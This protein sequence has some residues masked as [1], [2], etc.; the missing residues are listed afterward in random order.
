MVDEFQDVSLDQFNMIYSLS[1]QHRNLVCVGDCD[2][3]IYSFR[4]G[5]NRFALEFKEY[6]PD[7]QIVYMVDNFR[8]TKPIV[9]AANTLIKNNVERFDKT[10][11]SHKD[12]VPVLLY[13]DCIDSENSIYSSLISEGYAPGDIAVIAT[14]NKSLTYFGEKIAPDGS[15]RP[16]DYVVK[17]SVFLALLDILDL[18]ENGFE[19]DRTLYRVLNLAGATRSDFLNIKRE[20]Q[21]TFM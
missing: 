19:N 10:I 14:T 1:E 11:I 8:C 15:L 17:D 18:H 12:G 2:Q 7:A 13:R 4:G 21:Y 20:Y 5:S 6:F 9:E 16:K 3:A